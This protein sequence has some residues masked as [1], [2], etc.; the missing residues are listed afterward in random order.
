MFCWIAWNLWKYLFRYFDLYQFDRQILVPDFQQFSFKKL[1]L[2]NNNFESGS[3]NLTSL[4]RVQCRENFVWADNIDFFQ[5]SNERLCFHWFI[6]RASKISLIVNEI[7]IWSWNYWTDSS[8]SFFKLFFRN[9]R[10][11]FAEIEILLR[12]LRLFLEK[13]R[14]IGSMISVKLKSRI[15]FLHRVPSG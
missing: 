11:F 7:V 2:P 12:K 6:T 3:W 4:W 1:F 14:L 10:L 9:L 5:C 13:L 15:T 8:F